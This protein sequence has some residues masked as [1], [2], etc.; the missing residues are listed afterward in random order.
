MSAPDNDAAA[1][2]GEDMAGGDDFGLGV[3]FTAEFSDGLGWEQSQDRGGRGVGSASPEPYEIAV[4]DSLRETYAVDPGDPLSSWV[5]THDKGTGMVPEQF[6]KL[7]S[8]YLETMV[9]QADAAHAQEYAALES[10]WGANCERQLGELTLWARAAANDRRNSPRS[11][12]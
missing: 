2:G 6:R 11:S 3:E 4:P 8:G 7:T 9:R 5:R 1:P 12:A 10:E